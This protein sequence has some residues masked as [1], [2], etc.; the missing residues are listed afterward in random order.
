MQDVAPHSKQSKPKQ[1]SPQQADQVSL[2]HL[3]RV[4]V[5]PGAV[6][7]HRLPGW[8]AAGGGGCIALCAGKHRAPL[9]L[10]D[11]ST[12]LCWCPFHRNAGNPAAWGSQE[13]QKLP[14]TV[15]ILATATAVHAREV[16]RVVYGFRRY[17]VTLVCPHGLFTSL[18]MAEEARLWQLLA[19]APS[20]GAGGGRVL[21]WC[22]PELLQQERCQLG[23]R[24]ASCP[25]GARVRSTPLGFKTYN[26]LYCLLDNQSEE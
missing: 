17:A 25:R 5:L 19:A 10:Q 2:G 11:L 22:P 16:K 3:T 21:S 26:I 12:E 14:V 18:G 7:E 9:V 4:W 8:V 24:A 23:C 6:L 15:T 13:S 1:W 20:F